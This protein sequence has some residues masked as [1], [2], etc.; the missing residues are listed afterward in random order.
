MTPPSQRAEFKAGR[1][2]KAEATFN[3]CNLIVGSGILALPFAL[4]VSGGLWGMFLLLVVS[5]ASALSGLMVGWC[6]ELCEDEFMTLGVPRHLRDFAAIASVAFGPLGRQLMQVIVLLQLWFASEA[7]LMFLGWNMSMVFPI[8]KETAIVIAGIA[9][10]LLD[11]VPERSFAYVSL[12]GFVA[13]AL[14]IFAMVGAGVTLPQQEE[15]YWDYH[16]LVDWQGTF[17]A[18]GIVLFSTSSHPGLPAVFTRMRNP[19][20]DF[21][22]ACLSAFALCTLA[23]AAAALIGWHF[24]GNYV[25]ETFTAN[26]GLDL[27]GEWQPSVAMLRRLTCAAFSV[28]IQAVIPLA[29]RPVLVTIQSAMGIDNL[30]IRTK[31]PYFVEDQTMSTKRL[32][33]LRLASKIM[34]FSFSVWVALSFQQ[35]MELVM[36]VTGCFFGMVVAIIFPFAAYLALAGPS[37]GLLVWFFLGL[38]IVFGAVFAVVGSYKEISSLLLEV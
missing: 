34:L 38:G 14:S 35:Q 37:A 11:Y 28:K 18:I 32:Q 16:Y 20:G 27:N 21:S 29:I 15:P 8:T 12:V 1:L 36:A 22:G 4:R 13:A 17:S 30:K 3:M 9:A 23:H 2:S 26:I 10:F 24:Y 33:Q 7:W 25:S 19:E 6:L 5:A 31:P